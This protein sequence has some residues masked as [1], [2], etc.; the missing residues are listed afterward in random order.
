VT[1][2]IVNH[3]KIFM[4]F[5]YQIIKSIVNNYHLE[6]ICKILFYYKKDNKIVNIL[7]IINSCHRVNCHIK[8]IKEIFLLNQIKNS[9]MV[10]THKI[11]IN[12]IH[13][14]MKKKDQ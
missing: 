13:F 2:K 8:D 12:I 3:K 7:K 9:L 14:K 6:S 1:I 11:I 4:Y 5:T 10:W